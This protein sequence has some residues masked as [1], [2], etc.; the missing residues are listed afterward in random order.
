MSI[1]AELESRARAWADADPDDATQKELLALIDRARGGEAAAATELADRFA[2]TLEFGTAG[3]RG[4][5]AAGPNRMN[6]AVIL[7]TTFGLAEWV[8]TLPE[9]ATR[10]VVIGFDGR[11]FS[12][13]F[14]EDTA[15]VLAAAGVKAWLFG[16]L[17]PTPRLAF[18]VGAL[19]AAA[20]VMVTASHNPPEYNGYKVYGPNTAQIV[21]PIDVQIA[22]AIDRAPRAR[23]VPRADRASAEARGLLVAVPAEIERRYMDGIRAVVAAASG[24]ERAFPIVY[25]PLHGVGGD[26][27][28]RAFAESGFSH[29]LPVPEQLAPDGE[30]PTVAFPNPEERGAM[31]LSLAL[32]RKA[33]A[34]LVVANDPDADR[35][36]VAVPSPDAPGGWVQL[37]GNQVGALLGHHLLERARRAGTPK[38]LVIT[39]IV[40]SPMLGVMAAAAGARYEETLTG[41]KWIATRAMELAASD[42]LSFVFGY[43]EA[44]GYTPGTLVRDKDGISAAV[45]F[46]DMVA[47]L[48]ARGVSVLAQLEALARAHGLF[49]SDQISITKK[50]ADGAQ[51]IRAMMQRFRTEPPASVGGLEVLAVRDYKARTRTDRASGAVSALTLPPSDVV[52]FELAGGSRFIARPSGT[53]P[54]IKLYFDVRE[55]MEAGEPLARARARAEARLAAMKTDASALAVT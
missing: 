41:F 46:A 20:G 54:K 22:Q 4:V 36:A 9:G 44:L 47:E 42:G 2:G 13:T 30:F 21:S 53:E 32:A 1:P 40:S 51:A 34:E 6:R 17:G 52:A 15:L 50:G 3:L 33:S 23:E 12:R 7:R 11:R 14:A 19:G 38:P 8:R 27:A 55:P 31:D 49:V 43:E 26:I 5:I 16:D 45:V 25:T 48:R 35:L 29:V 28:L 18:A 37:T 10:G 24:I 39:T